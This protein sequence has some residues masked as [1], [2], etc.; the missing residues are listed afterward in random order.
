VAG[1]LILTVS[2]FLLPL[3]SS[4]GLLLLVSTGMATGNSLVTPTLNAMASR[5]VNAAWQGRAL[6]VMQSAASLARVIGPVL[7]GVLL[8]LQAR[9]SPRYVRAP[10]WTPG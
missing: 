9:S 8:S 2:M 7:G 6:G 10:V 4:L 3:S 1:S 5:S